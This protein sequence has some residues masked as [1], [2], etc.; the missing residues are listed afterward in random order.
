MK[1]RN[2]VYIAIILMIAAVFIYFAV[3]HSNPQVQRA[4][5]YNSS[6]PDYRFIAANGSIMNLSEFSGKPVVIWF[7]ATWCSSCAQGDEALNKSYQFF[8]QHNI[9]IIELEIYNDLGYK[10]MPIGQ[11][12]SDYAGNAY[13]NKTIIPAYAGYNMSV[14]YDPKGYLDIYYLVSG[15]GKIVYVNDNGMFDTVNQLIGAINKSI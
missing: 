7:V 8:R 11:F 9:K 10:G 1:K 2:L 6:A 4:A 5:V 15:S 12:V 3:G 14:A 13:L